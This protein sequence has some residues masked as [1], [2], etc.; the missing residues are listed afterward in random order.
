M[1]WKVKI[2]Q[3]ICAA[4]MRIM[5]SI[6]QNF[7]KNIARFRDVNANSYFRGF[8]YFNHYCLTKI[9]ESTTWKIIGIIN[10]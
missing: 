2:K 7:I 1:P 4:K 8:L 9:C 3:T 6:T 10:F 5:I